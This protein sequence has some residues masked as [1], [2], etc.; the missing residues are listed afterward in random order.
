M[1]AGSATFL[2]KN[3]QTVSKL[4]KIHPNVNFFFNKICN[5]FL[6]VFFCINIKILKL[7]CNITPPFKNSLKCNLEISCTGNQLT[8]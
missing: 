1:A 3:V 8:F 5:S 7:F 6:L 2:Y 4:S